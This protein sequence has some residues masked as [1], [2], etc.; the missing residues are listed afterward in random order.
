MICDTFD[1]RR[2]GDLHYFLGIEATRSSHTLQLKQTRYALDLLERFNMTS[3]KPATTP[4]APNSRLSLYEGDLLSDAT[5]YRSMVGGLQY[6]TLTRP[7]IT[8]SVNQV[9]Q[10]MHQPRTSHLQAAKR[11][12]RFIKDTT[13]GFDL[14]PVIYIPHPSLL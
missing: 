13:R 3:C 5:E 8:F 12:L 10:F 11:I 4:T 2:L 7:D 9:C 6:L 14:L 1:S